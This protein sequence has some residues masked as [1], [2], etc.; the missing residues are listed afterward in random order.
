MLVG[1]PKN[2]A[3][4]K[5]ETP[6]PPNEA[7]RADP[8]DE[9]WVPEWAKLLARNGPVDGGDGGEAPAAICDE[10]NDELSDEGTNAVAAG[11]AAVPDATVAPISDNTIATAGTPVRRTIK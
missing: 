6:A 1:L 8:A 11:V 10:L 9:G 5:A 4:P 2:E 7:A 3:L